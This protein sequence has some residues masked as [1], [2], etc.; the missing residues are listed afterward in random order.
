MISRLL[1]DFYQEMGD[2]YIVE[3]LEGTVEEICKP[4][5]PGTSPRSGLSISQKT[6]APVPR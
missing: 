3:H 1:T 4:G 6:A 2:S 5:C